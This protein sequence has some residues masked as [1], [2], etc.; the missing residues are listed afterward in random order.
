MES[1]INVDPD[2]SGVS[3]DATRLT[4]AAIECMNENKGR[5][6]KL[7]FLAIRSDPTFSKAWINLAILAPFRHGGQVYTA[8]VCL[9]RAHPD[10]VTRVLR[11]LEQRRDESHRNKPSRSAG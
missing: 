8:D 6:I 11:A 10:E 4:F 9:S 7:L 2:I 3:E 1:S 5:A